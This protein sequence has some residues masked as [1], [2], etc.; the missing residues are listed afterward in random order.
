MSDIP[1]K[2]PQQDGLDDF[3]Y[4][5][6]T[7]L[8]KN[9]TEKSYFTENDIVEKIRENK[10]GFFDFSKNMVDIGACYGAYAML[11]NYNHNYCFEP[12]KWFTCLIY[13][14]MYLKDKVNNTDVYNVALGD[15]DKIIKFDGFYCEGCE[16]TY[17]DTN[18]MYEV[19]C[20]MLDEYYL[21]NID[22]IKIDIEGFEERAIR[23]GLGTIIRNNYPSILFE[24]W[25]VGVNGMTQEK[26]DSL[27]NLLK[28]LGYNIFEYW[29][30]ADTHLAIHNSKLKN[31]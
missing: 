29:G 26:H 1:Y 23:G 25:D 4:I 31:N 8:I 3:Y 12:N 18:S 20:K 10:E 21:E 5:H 15:E 28:S 9:N 14:N 16:C 13:S 2:I 17:L 6:Y 11:L 22:F 27:F 7:A 30:S 24:C 19:Q